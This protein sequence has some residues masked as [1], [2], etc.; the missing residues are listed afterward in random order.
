M[1]SLVLED[2]KIRTAMMTV[3]TALYNL[4]CFLSLRF[5]GLLH[6]SMRNKILVKIAQGY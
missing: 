6:F 4:V 1:F 2:L 5:Y 3:S